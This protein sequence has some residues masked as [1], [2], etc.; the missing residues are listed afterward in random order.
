MLLKPKTLEVQPNLTTTLKLKVDRKGRRVLKKAAQAGKRGRATVTTTAV[1][2]L[3]LSSTD[4]RKVRF[5][6]K[7]R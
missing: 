6:K 5:K 4:K 2:D 1:D 7:R 3:G